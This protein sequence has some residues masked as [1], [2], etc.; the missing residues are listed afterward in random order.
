MNSGKCGSRLLV[1]A[2]VAVTMLMSSCGGDDG[3]SESG[4]FSEPRTSEVKGSG[5]EISGAWARMSPSMVTAGAAYM[6][7]EVTSEDRLLGVM[8]D[9]SVAGTAQVHETVMASTGTSDMNGSAMS[10]PMNGEMTMREVDHIDLKAGTPLELAPGGFH[11]MLMDLAA[12]LEVGAT[13]EI[14]LRFAEAGEVVVPV[15]VRA[16]AP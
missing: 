3:G 6:T 7:I 5:V 12:P 4:S 14:T 15:E 11:I 8:V 13:F 9:S 1:G 16:E 10:A 2:T